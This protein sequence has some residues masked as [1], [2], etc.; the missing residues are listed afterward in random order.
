MVVIAVA[1]IVAVGIAG[2]V[3]RRLLDAC[4]LHRAA[5]RIGLVI[6]VWIA[7]A[8]KAHHTVGV[9]GVHRAARL[10]DRKLLGIDADAIAMR[11]RIGEHPRLEHL[12]R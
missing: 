5:E 7:V 12:V 2:E 10:V 3:Q 8:G 11:V 6:G 4:V 1:M 9:I